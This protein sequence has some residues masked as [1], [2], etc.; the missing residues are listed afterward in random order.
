MRKAPPKKPEGEIKPYS[1]MEREGEYFYHI[2]LIHIQN[3]LYAERGRGGVDDSVLQWMGGGLKHSFVNRKKVIR[4]THT[5]DLRK[6]F[7]P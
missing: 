3:K 1:L 4:K 6:H 7:F 5:R 2:D